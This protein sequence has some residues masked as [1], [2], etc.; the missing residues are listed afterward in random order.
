MNGQK[1]DGADRQVDLAVDHQE[2]LACRQDR[3]RREVR[4]Q[5]LEVLDCEER[6]RGHG[7][8]RRDH[9]RDH[10]DAALAQR[11]EPADEAHR[12]GAGP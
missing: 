3:E 5:R 8:V 6:V 9:D 11:Q 4:Q 12:A 2:D 1:V 7:E 10:D